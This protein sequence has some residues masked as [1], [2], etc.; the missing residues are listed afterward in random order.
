MYKPYATNIKL[1]QNNLYKL[2]NQLLLE[3]LI[4]FNL[5]L[6]IIFQLKKKIRLYQ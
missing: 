5:I 3:L 2:E 4:A 6:F 1:L